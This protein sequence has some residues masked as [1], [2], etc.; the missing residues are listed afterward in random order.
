M[1]VTK[2][3]H[4]FGSATEESVLPPK[5]QRQKLHRHHELH[6]RFAL[7]PPPYPLSTY[8]PGGEGSRWRIPNILPLAVGG[9]WFGNTPKSTLFF[10]DYPG[11]RSSLPSCRMQSISGFSP[12]KDCIGNRPW[13]M[14]EPLG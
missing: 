4:K 10:S 11:E 7:T 5:N 14:R 2:K 1:V 9:E 8:S 13:K 3:Q 6:L 12:E